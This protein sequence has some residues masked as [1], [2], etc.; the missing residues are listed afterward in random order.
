[1]NVL[2]GDVG[3]TNAR[4]AVAETTPNGLALFHEAS[5][6]SADYPSLEAA[7]A[8]Y[9]ELCP[10]ARHSEVGS[11]GVAGPVRG[12]R[13]EIT[14]LGWEV[15]GGVV[16]RVVGLA[17]VILLN[18]LEAAAWGLAHVGSAGI[19]TFWAGSG[20]KSGRPGGHRA[21][22]A[23]GTGLGQALLYWD[24]E[25]HRPW[26]TEGGH[27]DLAPQDEIQVELWRF[28]R[29]RY[30]QHVS[31][32]RALSGPGLVSL[33]DFVVSREGGEEPEWLAAARA[34]GTAAAAID[35]HA[36]AGCPRS[37]A[38]LDLFFALLGA[39]AGNLALRTM[40]TGGIYLAGGMVPKLLAHLEAS[41]FLAAYV[42]KGRFRELVET[43]P[44]RVV[45]EDR[46]GLLGAAAR[47]TAGR[48]L[49]VPA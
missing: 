10:A 28:L 36:A 39:E 34:A 11:F 9:L 37:R 24:G 15:E 18:D 45:T 40:A 35:R 30:G 22:L 42:A 32:E 23:A 31:W 16:A 33:L 48:A 29:R 17:E 25:R 20:E 1:M 2:V 14:N 5:L 46:L 19:H 8:A 38:A 7:I 6:E 12:D 43:I 44:V 41:P 26:A 47:A 49:G 21:I 13:S 3:G 27:G 4:F